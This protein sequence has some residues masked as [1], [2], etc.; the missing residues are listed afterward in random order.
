MEKT[1]TVTPTFETV[2]AALME[3][4]KLLKESHLRQMETDKQIAELNKTV[5]G[6]QNANGS[7]A[8]Y[9]FF[10]SFD[11]GKKDFFGKTFES[12]EKNMR[13][14]VVIDEYD[15]VIFGSTTIA[16][17]ETK[18]KMRPEDVEKV[19]KK[20]ETFRINFPMYQNHQ[21]YLGLAALVPSEIVERDCIEEGIAVIKQI[22]DTVVINDE[23]L[24]VF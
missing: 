3:T 14:R 16:I 4:D 22:G 12:I 20:A 6:M 11:N 1:D 17:I 5:G 15:I 19:I 23:H 24:N 21:I 18:Y 13:G 10:N 7:F 9:Y 8:E 2:W